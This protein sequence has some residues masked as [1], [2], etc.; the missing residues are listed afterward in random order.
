[1]AQAIPACL[2]KVGPR[3]YSVRG[4]PAEIIEREY[5][6]RYA[7]WALDFEEHRFVQVHVYSELWEARDAYRRL[8]DLP[9]RF[10]Q[11]TGEVA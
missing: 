9:E 2:T 7:L 5:D 8:D 3:T 4:R 6:G 11:A 1:M 10:H